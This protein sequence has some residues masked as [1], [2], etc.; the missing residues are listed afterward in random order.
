MLPTLINLIPAIHELC[1]GAEPAP[2]GPP[3][4]DSRNIQAKRSSEL[5]G[6]L[7]QDIGPNF[8]EHRKEVGRVVCRV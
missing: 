8:H 6:N 5:L 7:T 4:A 1:S 2:Y 3:Q